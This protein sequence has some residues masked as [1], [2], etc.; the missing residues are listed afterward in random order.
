MLSYTSPQANSDIACFKN[1]QNMIKNDIS[2]R[3]ALLG[4]QRSM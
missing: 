2:Q 4:G 1:V 3:I